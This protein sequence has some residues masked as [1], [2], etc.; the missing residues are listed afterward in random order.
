MTPEVTYLKQ[1]A[2]Q[3]WRQGLIATLVTMV[4]EV[5]HGVPIV[6][7][8]GVQENNPAIGELLSR[9]ERALAMNRLTTP[10]QENAVAYLEQVLAQSPA[11]PRARVLLNRVIGRYAVLVDKTV[12]QSEQA[13]LRHLEKVLI[14][15]DRAGRVVLRHGLESHLLDHMDQKIAALAE[16]SAFAEGPVDGRLSELVARH[17]ALARTYLKQND[18]EEA[19]WHAE[20]AQAL[21]SRYGFQDRRLKDL[22]QQ[23]ARRQP[24]QGEQVVTPRDDENRLRLTELAAF[25]IAS[26]R[27]AFD[28]GNFVEAKRRD[29]AA[30]DLI[31]EYGLSAATAD[32][33]SDEFQVLA[34]TRVRPS[35]FRVYGTF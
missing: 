33:L 31:T 8:V 35:V 5:G 14:L 13:R 2:V 34:K 24:G 3:V 9:A 29:R 16:P 18:S 6:Q 11:H 25:Y 26:S 20:Q 27:A 17:V 7:A 10:A 12:A 4:L 30:R 21:A 19:A 1:M 22:Q 23:V 32:R 28:Q 15:R